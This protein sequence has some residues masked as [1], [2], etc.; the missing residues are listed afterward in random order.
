L[1]VPDTTQAAILF[2]IY[3]LAFSQPTHPDAPIMPIRLTIPQLKQ[4]VFLP[5]AFPDSAVGRE[6][7]SQVISHI[8]TA[9]ADTALFYIVPDALKDH[10]PLPTS[11]T[12]ARE[13]TEHAKPIGELAVAVKE[14][15]EALAVGRRPRSDEA[16]PEDGDWTERV[17]RARTQYKMDRDSLRDVPPAGDLLVQAE[18]RWIASRPEKDSLEV[19]RFGQAAGIHGLLADDTLASLAHEGTPDWAVGQTTT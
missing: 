14:E 11:H 1:T 10:P 18:Q 6:D 13:P 9:Q 15:L 17:K 5:Q 8:L 2:A 7:V 19:G 4:L 3:T 16:P 12:L